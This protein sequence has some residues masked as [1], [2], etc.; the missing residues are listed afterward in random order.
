VQLQLNPHFIYN[1]ISSIGSLIST[2]QNERANEYL[3]A[4]SD[5]MRETLKNQDRQLVNLDQDI[6]ALEKYIRLEQLRFGFRYRIDTDPELDL[7]SLR[8]PPMLLQPIIENAV[9]YALSHRG[10]QGILSV[11]FRKSGAHLTV[12]VQ[13]NGSGSAGNPAMKSGYGLLFT[14]RR[15]ANLNKLYKDTLISFTLD[16]PEPGATARFI[17]N[18]WLD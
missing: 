1:A 13:D 6:R 5:I 3:S 4:F 8:F 15:I 10:E 14:R 17:F 18:N 16:L 7:L 9:K 2:R 11:S 12:T